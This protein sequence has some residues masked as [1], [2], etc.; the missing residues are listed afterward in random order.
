MMKVIIRERGIGRYS[1]NVI[2]ADIDDV[3]QD[4]N[5]GGSKGR[6]RWLRTWLTPRRGLM[7]CLALSSP[8]HHPCCHHA[9]LEQRSSVISSPCHHYGCCYYSHDILMCGGR[10]ASMGGACHRCHPHHHH[11]LHHHCHHQVGEKGRGDGGEP[12]IIQSDEM[13]EVK[14]IFESWLIDNYTSFIWQSWS[15]LFWHHDQLFSSWFCPDDWLFI[16]WFWH[17]DWLL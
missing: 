5:G 6:G 3:S 10:V 8:C 1:F 11:H 15:K 17:N 16:W 14:I 9:H 4:N 12:V 13:Q 7:P 2:T